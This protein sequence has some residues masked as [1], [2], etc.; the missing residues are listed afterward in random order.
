MDMKLLEEGGQDIR[1]GDLTLEAYVS[2]ASMR[3]RRETFYRAAVFNCACAVISAAVSC[4]VIA[5]NHADGSAGAAF[6]FGDPG[7]VKKMLERFF[8]LACV[9]AVCFASARTVLCRAVCAAGASAC[10]AICGAA[11]FNA[12]RCVRQSASAGAAPLLS[13]LTAVYLAAATAVFASACVSF[14][15]C[16]KR[17]GVTAE[18]GDTLF[19]YLMT[20]LSVLLVSCALTLLVPEIITLFSG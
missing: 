4:Y 7:T 1:T 13:A 9:P 17:Y 18:D 2:I 10:G 19:A 15:A 16:R 14:Y 3:K 12:V 8:M 11:V 6:L 5:E 20:L